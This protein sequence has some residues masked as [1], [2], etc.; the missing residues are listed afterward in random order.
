[1]CVHGELCYIFCLMYVEEEPASVRL[2]VCANDE[3]DR[4]RG[5]HAV[6]HP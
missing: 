1:M 3:K 6:H 5:G 4:L 2:W